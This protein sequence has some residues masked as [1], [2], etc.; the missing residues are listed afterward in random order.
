MKW[1]Y[2]ERGEQPE[3]ADRSRERLTGGAIEVRYQRTDQTA[4]ASSEEGSRTRSL[5]GGEC[6]ELGLGPKEKEKPRAFV[7]PFLDGS[8]TAA[9]QAV[10]LDCGG[11]H[12]VALTSNSEIVTWGMN[13]R[14]AEFDDE[15]EQFSPKESTPIQDT[16]GKLR[17]IYVDGGLIKVLHTPSL[18]LNLENITQIVCGANHAMA[19]DL[20]GNVWAW[21]VNQKSQL[22][23]HL[24]ESR[25][26]DRRLLESF[27]PRRVNLRWNK[28]RNIASGLEHSFAIDQKDNVWAWGLNQ[29]GQAGYA[30]DAGSDNISLP[31]PM[32]ISHLG[33]KNITVSSGGADH[34]VAVTTDG[35][36]LV[37]GRID[38]G[39]LGIELSD[40]QIRDKILVRCDGHGRPLICLRPVAVPNIG[41]A[42]YVAC[43]TGHTVF[44]NTEGKAYGS[45]FGSMGQLEI[46][47][48]D[49]ATVAEKIIG[50]AGKGKILTWFGAG[51]HFSIVASPV[52]GG[53]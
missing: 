44:V 1:E 38:R 3:E 14:D 30:K 33:G 16:E 11:M 27:R 8:K 36:C 34:S 53:S 42:A 22:G 52:E 7:N 13:D 20:A 43:G 23:Y 50:A 10:Q 6:G 39:Q 40:E 26:Y 15:D 45:G 17:F 49:G 24:F 29:N 41:T 35:Q 2:E 19:L 21:G 32:K 18:I 51:R 48:E 37:W 9:F 25:R 47:S 4:P 5:A 28:A 12:I 46:A 31:D